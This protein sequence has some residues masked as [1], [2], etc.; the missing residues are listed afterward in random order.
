MKFVSDYFNFVTTL[1]S[2]IKFKII[3]LSHMGGAQILVRGEEERR[4]KFHTSIPFKLCTT[5]GVAKI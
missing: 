4:T 5:N 2:D 1:L 3:C